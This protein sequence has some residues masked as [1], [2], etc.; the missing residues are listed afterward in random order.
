MDDPPTVGG[1]VQALV[2][3]YAAGLEHYTAWQQR[4]WRENQY[5]TRSPRGLPGAG[6]CAATISLGTSAAKISEAYDGGADILGRDFVIGDEA[7]RKTLLRHLD[8]LRARVS[9]L[10]RAAAADGPLE[11][12]ELIRVSE[13]ARVAC[14]AALSKLYQRVAVGRLVPS[15]LPQRSSTWLGKSKEG[16]EEEETA[17]AGG[18]WPKSAPRS[19]AEEEEEEEEDEEVE[20][21]EEAHSVRSVNND[22]GGAP[23]RRPADAPPSSTRSPYQSEP[24]S[25]PPT[26]PKMTPDQQHAQPSS[27]S[28]SGGGGR[29]GPR[30]RAGARAAAAGVGTTRTGCGLVEAEA[31]RLPSGLRLRRPRRGNGGEHC[32]RTGFQITPRFL[33]KSHCDGRPLPQWSVTTETN[34]DIVGLQA[35]SDAEQTDLLS[36]A[37]FG[38]VMGAVWPAIGG[39]ALAAIANRG[40]PPGVAKLASTIY[41]SAGVYQCPGIGHAR[42]RPQLGGYTRQGRQPPTG[43]AAP[44][45]AAQDGGKDTS[46]ARVS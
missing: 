3:T 15:E 16:E 18:E 32:S 42:P 35:Y 4:R 21:E 45:A 33:G 38:L 19:T 8:V 44:H 29:D 28:R 43:R 9:G 31:H 12:A 25:P 6:F 26:P 22:D 1:A 37:G 24:P 11:L 23:S 2:G 14:L 41:S 10:Q 39:S 40:H 17:A 36:L 7:C 34:R 5:L 27:P 13:A 20:T 46:Y 30:G